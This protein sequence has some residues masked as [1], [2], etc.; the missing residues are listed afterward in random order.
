MRFKS[1][2]I[3]FN[4]SASTV[5]AIM[6][7]ILAFCSEA[8]AQ[9][10]TTARIESRVVN[11]LTGTPIESVRIEIR[12][13]TGYP[14]VTTT[15]E[16]GRF[17]EG[18]FTSPGKYRYK[19]S[20]KGY[21]TL[22]LEVTLSF[23]SGKI[24]GLPYPIQLEPITVQN[25]PVA[26]EPSTSSLE[27]VEPERRIA[28]VIGNSA[29]EASPLKNPVNDARDMAA[30]LRQLGFEVQEGIDL[31]QREM[32]QM[33]REFGQKLKSGGVGLFY[34]AGHGV[35]L[36]GQNYLIPL[37]VDIQ[38]E[39]D[40]EDLAV[41]A[42]LVLN[43]MDEAGNRLNIVILDACRNNPFARSFRS[44]SRGLAMMDAPSGTLIAY[45][46]APGS[47]ASDGKE[48][49]GLYTQE[50]LKNIKTPGLG[51]EDI[52]KR[53]RISVTN[54]TQKKQVPWD[55]SSLTSD[56]YISGMRPNR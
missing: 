52:F 19:F 35:Q 28:L 56:F 7:F 18:L 23:V 13:D 9:V 34:Y 25:K 44:Q 40:V 20:A 50:L 36:K 2:S 53:V 30:T 33:I 22:E 42:D 6:L 14:R 32:R 21:K 5:F 38:S 12:N 48:R 46:T 51:I 47:V 43:L 10:E 27:P 41:S 26:R 31:T 16:E 24:T 45:A 1:Y 54:L 39:A 11:K 29:Y 55:A 4:I 8:N 17:F 15:D 3:K 49:N 37:K